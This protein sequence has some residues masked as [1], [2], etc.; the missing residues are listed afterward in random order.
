MAKRKIQGITIQ[1]VDKF[2]GQ[3]IDRQWFKRLTDA[4]LWLNEAYPNWEKVYEIE[5]FS[6]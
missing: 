4:Y 1:L 2:T 3:A 5:M 6:D